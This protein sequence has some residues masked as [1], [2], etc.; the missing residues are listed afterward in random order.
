MK[1]KTIIA[2]FFVI[3][4][5]SCGEDT[6][7][8]ETNDDS[9]EQETREIVR[10]YCAW[11]D[12]LLAQDYEG[13][14]ALVV[15]GSNGEGATN[16]VKESWDLGFQDY[17]IFTYVEHDVNEDDI[18]RNEGRAKGNFQA[19]QSGNG[20]YEEQNAGFYSSCRK[21]S[22]QWK[23]EGLNWNNEEDWWGRHHNEEWP[24]ICN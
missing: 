4:L 20:I 13:A 19:I 10:L 24:E 12:R 3:S 21:I 5:F 11:S 17:V 7:Q 2:F 14:L 23:I 16:V 6:T 18:A 9:F 15:P 1:F 22:G 8:E